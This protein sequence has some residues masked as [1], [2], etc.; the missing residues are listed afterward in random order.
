M[1]RSHAKKAVCGTLPYFFIRC[2]G[3]LVDPS[4]LTI[5]AF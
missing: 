1:Q 2:Y 3:D 4:G 5:R